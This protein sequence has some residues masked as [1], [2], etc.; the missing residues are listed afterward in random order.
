[1]RVL[2]FGA[3]AERAGMDV[4]ESHAGSLALLK[5]DLEE[6]I[7]G[8]R[9]MSYALAVDRKLMIGDAPLTGKE[10]VAVLPPF[11]GG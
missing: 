9:E 2:L 1:M 7:I 10:E 4:I 3:I 8:L 5:Q 6:R 11:A